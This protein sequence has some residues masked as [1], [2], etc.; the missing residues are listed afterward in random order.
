MTIWAVKCRKKI[1][2][3][4]EEWH[5]QGYFDA[6]AKES[7]EMFHFGGSQWIRS[8]ASK[9]FIRYHILSVKELKK[10]IKAA[11]R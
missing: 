3:G 7:R 1:A 9:K 5:W 10:I 4:S 11:G 2:D 6:V 8:A